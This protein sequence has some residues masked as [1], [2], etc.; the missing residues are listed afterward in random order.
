MVWSL[1]S[2]N[3]RESS[4][5]AHLVVPYLQGK[6]LDIGCGLDKIWPDVL[7]VDDLKDYAGQRPP[8]IDMVCD[9]TN[10]HF[11]RDEVIDGIYSSHFLEHTVDFK[12]V[13]KEWWRVIRPDG[14][15]VLYLPHKS[16]YPNIGQPGSNPD[17]KHDFMPDDIIDAMK[18]IGSW[19][20]VEN[21]DRNKTNE[22]SFFQVYRKI[23]SQGK[24]RI[25][26]MNVWERN[27]NGQQRCLIVRYGAIGDQILA[28]SILPELKKQGYYITYNTAPNGY[29]ILKHDPNI[30]EWIVQA[31]DYVPNPQLGPYWGSLAAEGRWDKIINLCESIEG[32][33]LTLPGRLQFDYPHETRQKLFSSVNYLER[34]HDIAGVPYNFAPK[35]YPT[36]AETAWAQKERAKVKAPIVAWSIHGSAHHKV[37]PWTQIVAAWL[38]THTPCH[39]FLLGDKQ[40]G[41]PLQDGIV[42]S[43]KKDGIDLSKLHLMS[44]EWDI[45]QALTFV[46]QVDCL[47]GPETGTLNAVCMEDVK[48]VIYLSH[49]SHENLTKHWKNT[50]VLLPDKAKAPCWPCNR[51]HYNWDNCFQDKDTQASLCASAIPPKAVFEAIMAALNFKKVPISE[52]PQHDPT[53]P[54]G[55]TSGVVRK[56]A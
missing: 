15:L 4:K 33:L 55:G 44:G 7:G 6:C 46:N 29:E 3:G 42:D 5:I 38:L 34:T 12:A 2:S 48:K 22:Y 9:G 41:K 52:K 17:H 50:T 45:R 1:E 37:Y 49:S 40:S 31:K 10:L 54:S 25:H 11:Y 47:V 23:K 36:I 27:P 19:E 35:F 28:S 51:L 8:G 43:M 53:T 18:V 56:A 14:Y 16:F 24:K 13:L 20:L 32:G 21:E 26:K 39:V 30:D